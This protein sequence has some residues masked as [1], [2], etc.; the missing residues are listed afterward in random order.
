MVMSRHDHQYD[1]N[2]KNNRGS[3]HDEGTTTAKG[4]AY[5]ERE[6]T[7]KARPPTDPMAAGAGVAGSPADARGLRRQYGARHGGGQSPERPGRT[8]PYLSAVGDHGGQRPA[9][10][11]YDPLAQ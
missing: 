1:Y 10:C 2:F 9:R 8:R 3:W 11:R 5:A 6:A 7:I 4:N